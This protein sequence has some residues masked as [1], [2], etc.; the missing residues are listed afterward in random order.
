MGEGLNTAFQRMEEFRL[1]PPIIVEDGNYIKVIIAHT[2]LATPEE[3]IMEYLENNP[4]IKNREARQ[5]SGVKS[6]N[7][8]K[9]HFY[10]LRDK[11]LIEPVLSLG[12]T[13]IIAWKKKN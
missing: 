3:R 7:V 5:I 13:K 6:E 2:S 1:K 12:G 4:S 11:G 9:R 10:D 8:M